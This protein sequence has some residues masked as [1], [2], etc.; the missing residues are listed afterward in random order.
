MS[1]FCKLVAKVPRLDD[2]N[3]AVLCIDFGTSSTATSYVPEVSYRSFERAF[4]P[5]RGLRP[6]THYVT[7]ADVA[8]VERMVRGN[9]VITPQ[10]EVGVK[11]SVPDMALGLPPVYCVP[12]FYNDSRFPIPENDAQKP[13]IPTI[14]VRTSDV[15]E[16]GNGDSSHSEAA[17]PKRGS[18]DSNAPTDQVLIGFEAERAI[19]EGNRPIWQN[20]CYAP[21]LGIGAPIIGEQNSYDQEKDV[22]KQ[23]PVFEF[24]R[25]YFNNVYFRLL[26]G[27]I[28]LRKIDRICYSY[29]VAWVKHQRDT[30]RECLRK[31]L[32][33]SFISARVPPED[34][35]IIDP[36]HE[37]FSLD[38]A[39]AA[40]MGFVRYR[41]HGLEGKHLVAAFQPFE[42]G[43]DAPKFPKSIW[44]LA[45]DA[46]GGTTDVALL[47][48]IDTGDPYKPVTS[49]VRAYY[50]LPKA[51]LEMTR[52]IAENLKRRILQA[53]VD[54]DGSPTGHLANTVRQR[55]RTNLLDS[56]EA[57]DAFFTV[58]SDTII[59]E[60]QKRLRLI[61]DFFAEAERIKLELISKMRHQ[62]DAE[63]KSIS[64][65]INWD[66]PKYFIKS[67]IGIDAWRKIQPKLNDQNKIDGSIITNATSTIFEPMARQI[68]TW[69]SRELIKDRLGSRRIDLVLLVG[70][71]S[72]VPQ[73]QRIVLKAIPDVHKPFATNLITHDNLF[74]HDSGH[75]NPIDALKA[76]V[77][78][79]LHLQYAN[80]TIT[81]GRAL[82]CKPIE[83]TGRH[84]AIGIVEQ[85]INTLRPEK[86]FRADCPL[87]VEADGS[88]INP[89]ED[90]IYEETQAASKG[91]FIAYNYL[92]TNACKQQQYDDPRPFLRVRIEGGD[93]Y[94]YRRARF[95]F[96]QISTSEIFL[97]RVEI[98]DAND[99]C[100]GDSGVQPTPVTMSRGQKVEVKIEGAQIRGTPRKVV[101]TV[102]PYPFI[103][104]F[105]QTGQIHIDGDDAI[106]R[107][108][109]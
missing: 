27:D 24:L 25:E 76:A 21:K 69:F 44:V 77:Q 88:D 11:L 106:D 80:L 4:C 6:A 70:R 35:A 50:G 42:P 87:L 16:H 49:N 65:V 68:Q 81:R 64:C 66:D 37:G 46:G 67:A 73:V 26:L 48:I 86:E 3:S 89:E 15:L 30:L 92:G 32:Y 74:L 45:I 104:D 60:R 19:F 109:S 108:E 85:N 100:C 71:T 9:K 13:S 84:L 1:F 97:Y 22:E 98:F 28:P 7:V 52:I 18:A 107:D 83:V 91:F 90:L 78:E 79:G 33:E 102:E 17:D 14:L 57:L 94:L 36:L 59:T 96:R 56:K 34:A 40:F 63:P 2:V 53:A 54:I 58:G 8:R 5:V 93:P 95:T 62:P 103:V 20:P 61:R 29:P 39:S 82:Q 99:K 105:R 43:P 38:E 31:A 10:I 47:E 101:I 51:G 55:L 41:F 72:L 23:S 75:I 12:E